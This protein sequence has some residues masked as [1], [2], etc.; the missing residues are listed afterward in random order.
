MESIS[1]VL[2]K[3]LG[4]DGSTV[5]GGVGLPAISGLFVGVFDSVADASPVVGAY[6]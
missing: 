1:I 5:V 4:Q 6:V 2:E 3:E